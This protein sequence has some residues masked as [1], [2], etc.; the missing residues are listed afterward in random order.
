MPRRR[1]PNKRKILPDPK[2]QDRLVA[3]FINDLMRKG[4]KS[5]AE[6]IAY[7]AFALIEERAK[8]EPLKVFKRALDNV[9]P[10]LEVKSRRVGGA[11][12][13]VPVEVRQDRRVALA[14]RWII[15]YGSD[16][17]EKTMM[18]KLAGE[19]MDA[20]NNRGNAVKKKEDTHKMAEAN[21]AFSHYRW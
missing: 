2:F 3:K 7:R 9:K 8:E 20:A 1:V 5:T 6:Q 11:T 13:Q 4:K 15:E 14:M 12:Y 19:I 18:E 17:G 16:R 21:K 10:V